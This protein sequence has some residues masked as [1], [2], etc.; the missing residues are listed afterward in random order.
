MDA[1]AAVQFMLNVAQPQST[2]IGGGCFILY[3]H[4]ATGSLYALDG[5][6]EAPAAFLPNMFCDDPDCRNNATCP[7]GSGP[8]NF[9]DRVTGG[10]SVGVPGTLAAVDR[11]LRVRVCSPVAMQV[12]TEMLLAGTWHLALGARSGA[13]YRRSEARAANESIPPRQNRQQQSAVGAV[14]GLS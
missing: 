6:E 14:P 3:Y 13:G 2:G 7:C 11:L 10:N 9:E 12:L 1:A 8:I 5:R 4:A